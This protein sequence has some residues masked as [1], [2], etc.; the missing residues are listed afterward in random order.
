MT[1]YLTLDGQLRAETDAEIIANLRRKGWQDAPA[2]PS[3]DAVWQDGAWVVP[4]APTFTAD[5]WVDAQGYD[6]KRPTT[7]LYLLL[8]LQ[9]AGKSSPKLAAVQ[10]WMD[11][12]IAAGVTNPNEARSDWPV[13]PYSFQEA[14]GEALAVLQTV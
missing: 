1:T 13:A 5:Q 11:G 6:G 7:C 10:A 2:K 4:P 3:D 9:A 8:Q 14:S 12:M